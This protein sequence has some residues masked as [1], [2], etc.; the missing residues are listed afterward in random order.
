MWIHRKGSSLIWNIRAGV[1]VTHLPVYFSYI[2][3]LFTG[4]YIYI[5]KYNVCYQLNQDIMY[6]N[7]L[8]RCIY[9]PLSTQKQVDYYYFWSKVNL[10]FKLFIREI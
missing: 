6:M 10:Y 2:D 1:S 3:K 9:A 5:Y 8:Q 4:S 7:L